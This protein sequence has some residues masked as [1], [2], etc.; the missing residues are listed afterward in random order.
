MTNDDDDDRC[1]TGQGGR[2]TMGKMKAAR[3]RGQDATGACLCRFDLAPTDNGAS[4]GL[5]EQQAARQHSMHGVALHG[6]WH[7]N[8][9]D[10]FPVTGSTSHT[11]THARARAYGTGVALEEGWRRIRTVLVYAR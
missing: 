8:G 9:V 11:R 6:T 7:S 5:K 10:S 4:G 3:G 1:L 2:H